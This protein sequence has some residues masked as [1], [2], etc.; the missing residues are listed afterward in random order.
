[1]IDTL[2]T[3]IATRIKASNPDDTASIDVLKY[4]LILV[5]N[6]MLIL[7]LTV[8]AG[9]CLGNLPDVLTS[10]VAFVLLRSV[11][12]GAHLNSALGCVF[13]STG[14]AVLPSFIHLQAFQLH[15]VILL[16][17]LLIIIYA[18]SRLE[19]Y[20]NFPQHLYPVLKWASLMIVSANLFIQSD[21]LAVT[22]LIQS[23]TLIR[24]K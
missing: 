1:M 18:P 14:I 24:V 19:Q 15:S 6:F 3:R 4:G 21:L 17:C 2:A 13:V 8:I 7:L 22:F 5:I 9:L 12:G 11:S 20:S 16:S 10:F 23:L